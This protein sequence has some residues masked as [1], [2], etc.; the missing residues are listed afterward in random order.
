MLDTKAIKDLLAAQ[1]AANDS[2]QLPEND[3]LE[4]LLELETIGR[5]LTAV[6]TDANTQ[7]DD[8]VLHATYGCKD[9][10][11]LL[12]GKLKIH[13]SE[14]KRRTRLV[15][16][17]PN[18]PH[19]RDAMYAGE[20]SGE[21]ALVIS[22]A[23]KRLP[24]EYV[25]DA[26][27][28]LADVASTLDPQFL[29]RAGKYVRTVVDPDG[30]YRDE[31]DA[32]ARRAARM[33]R[34][35]DG[36]LSFSATVG[37]LDGEKIFNF[38][39]ALSKP[40]SV[41]GEKDPRTFE[42][43]L[44]D[45]FVEAMTIAMT[46]RDLPGL[47]RSLLVVTMDA[48]NLKDKT[49]CARTDTGQP[50]S[51]GLAQHTACDADI[52]HIVLGSEGEPLAYGRTRRLAS[53][54]QR[55]ALAVRDKGCAFPGCDRPPAWTEAHHVVHWIDG[56]PTDLDNLVLLCVYHHHVM[57]EQDWVIIFEQGIPAFIPLKWID[58]DQAP[59]RNIR[60]DCPLTL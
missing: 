44:A 49:G 45:A 19:T 1:L 55:R 58:P 8:R 29:M 6:K 23:I 34:D 51:P 60:V 31:K 4:F 13:P 12:C 57:H 42:Q 46:A 15:R 24:S 53:P 14:A 9:L 59:L 40:R 32:I 38:L 27:R 3:H 26:D 17:L 30:V 39:M 36:S 56:G 35:K 47:P 21:H 18:L 7:A 33:F 5:L 52:A 10:A 25:A 41:D 16:E 28:V 22:D 20:I 48:D 37:P 2:Y 50:V 54:A 11:M 43:R